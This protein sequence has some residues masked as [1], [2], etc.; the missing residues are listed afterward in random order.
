MAIV[1]AGTTNNPLLTI[2]SKHDKRK[3]F[4]QW[5]TGQ[6]LV[7]NC[8]LNPEQSTVEFVIPETN[9]VV[10][11]KVYEYNGK[12]VCDVPDELLEKAESFKVYVSVDDEYGDKTIYER[13]FDVKQRDKPADYVSVTTNEIE[14]LIDESEVLEYDFT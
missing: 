12:M 9:E 13:T 14:M 7:I 4:Y 2:Y 3:E 11:V 5:D 10:A 1:K 8:S 6:R